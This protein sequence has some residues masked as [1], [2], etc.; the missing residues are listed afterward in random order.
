MRFE[1]FVPVSTKS[2]NHKFLQTPIG[3]TQSD[4]CSK[5]VSWSP[6][7]A[8][9]GSRLFDQSYINGCSST[10]KHSSSYL[11]RDIWAS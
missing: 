6:I 3:F 7:R 11:P 2:N 1:A 9:R 10:D 4:D 8:R 5:V